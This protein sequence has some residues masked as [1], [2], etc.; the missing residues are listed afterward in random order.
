[1]IRS[2]AVVLKSCFLSFLCFLGVGRKQYKEV[3]VRDLRNAREKLQGDDLKQV[4]LCVVSWR[5]HSGSS[6]CPV[7]LLGRMEG[8]NPE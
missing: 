2:L 4:R 1:M 5:I 3:F 8:L 7:S 6:V